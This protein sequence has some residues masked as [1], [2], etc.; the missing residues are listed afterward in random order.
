MQK[1]AELPQ[2]LYLEIPFEISPELHLEI[3][4]AIPSYKQIPTP[5]LPIKL[6]LGLLGISLVGEFCMLNKLA[7]RH[8]TFV[9]AVQIRG[10]LAVRCQA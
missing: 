1:Y 5:N 7:L 3:H 2:E 8:L 4:F 10:P 9:V 6:Q